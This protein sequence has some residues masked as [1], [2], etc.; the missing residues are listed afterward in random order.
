MV[1]FSLVHVFVFFRSAFQDYA[2]NLAAITAAAAVSTGSKKDQLGK[3]AEKEPGSGTGSALGGT[4]S[5]NHL[6]SLSAIAGAVSSG[7]FDRAATAELG[8]GAGGGGMPSAQEAMR[9]MVAHMKESDPYPC[10]LGIPVK[11]TLFATWKMYVFVCFTI[12]ST[13]LMYDIISSL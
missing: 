5:P 8:V 6:S 2:D 9:C 10:V 11:P 3:S 13:K 1:T 4:Q 12:I 7:R